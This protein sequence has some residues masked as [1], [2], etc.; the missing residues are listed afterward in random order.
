[1]RVRG[2][3]ALIRR[4]SPRRWFVDEN[5]LLL[6]RRLAETRDDVVHPGHPNLAEVPRGA[7]DETWLEVVGR[8]ELIVITRDKRIRY[9]PVERQRWIDHRVRGFVLTSA[10]NMRIDEQ[11]ALLEDRWTNMER[12]V[13][14]RPGGP[15]MCSVT[16]SGIRTLIPQQ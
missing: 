4:V 15:W 16:R 6:A 8:L 10:G 14:A 9:R 11:L 1:M 7:S 2:D 13:A 3:G 12:L 5:N